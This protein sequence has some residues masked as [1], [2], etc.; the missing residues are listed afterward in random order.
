MTLCFDFLTEQIYS[1]R[2]IKG[3]KKLVWN[4]AVLLSQILLV[5]FDPKPFESTEV[6]PLISVTFGLVFKWSWCKLGVNMYTPLLYIWNSSMEWDYILAYVSNFKR[7]LRAPINTSSGNVVC[8]PECQCLN[9]WYPF[10]WL[11]DSWFT[12]MLEVLKRYTG[13]KTPASDLP[14]GCFIFQQVKPS[15]FDFAEIVLVE[16]WTNPAKNQLQH[17]LKDM[18]CS[19]LFRP[20]RFLTFKQL[21]LGPI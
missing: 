13:A 5:G 11:Q 19:L 17:T 15:W 10:I 3:K 7:V 21:F 1:T 6:F 12:L 14:F 16:N 2:A 8:M 20:L 9:D 18:F 4:L